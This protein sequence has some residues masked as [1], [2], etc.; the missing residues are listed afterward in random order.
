[1]THIAIHYLEIVTPKVDATCAAL[2][3]ARGVT[4]GEPVAELGGARTAQLA[5]GGL[6]GVR[7]PLRDDEDPVVRPYVLVD[8]VASA[9]AEAEAN[10]AAVAMGPTPMPG[11][12][13]FAIYVLGGI[14]HGLWQL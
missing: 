4:F 1:M 11:R 10:G 5:D 8:D 7:G 6:L 2:S 14:E 3:A 12:G 13:V 9:L